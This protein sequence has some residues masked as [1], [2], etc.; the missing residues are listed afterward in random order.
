[1]RVHVP[2]FMDECC[3][4][5]LPPALDEPTHARPLLSFPV[6]NK[7]TH[8][9][10]TQLGGDQAPNADAGLQAHGDRARSR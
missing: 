6:P 3:I 10:S 4:P 9:T 7:H 1:M 5:A 8:Q 2:C